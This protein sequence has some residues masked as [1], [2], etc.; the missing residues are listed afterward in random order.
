MTPEWTRRA[1]SVAFVLFWGLA[2][3]G[4]SGCGRAD[5]KGDLQKLTIFHQTLL[6]L[7]AELASAGGSYTS[8]STAALDRHDNAALHRAAGVYR[9]ALARLSPVAAR[10]RPPDFASGQ[11]S[12]HARNALGSLLAEIDA[13]ATAADA[14][15]RLS[16]P[17]APDAGA[18]AAAAA[19]QQNADGASAAQGSEIVEAYRAL[20]VPPDKV[21][22]VH[23]GLKRRPN[24]R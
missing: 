6:G 10:L 12:D 5:P 20:D 19:A 21:D 4:L 15:L 24:R 8:A 2:F 16:D 17:K 23:G 14:V 9:G 7:D 11:V 13:R 18:L 3:L 1:R 22:T